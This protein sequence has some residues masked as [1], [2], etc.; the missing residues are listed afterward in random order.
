V[1]LT[2]G[3]CHQERHQIRTG[4]IQYSKNYMGYPI[5]ICEKT[6]Y[7]SDKAKNPVRSSNLAQ[8]RGH[9]KLPNNFSSEQPYN[10]ATTCHENNHGMLQNNINGSSTTRN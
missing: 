9:T 10:S 1:S 3:L 5:Q 4:T 8:A 7:S 6:I 2:P